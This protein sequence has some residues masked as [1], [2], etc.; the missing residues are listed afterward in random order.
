MES[1]IFLLLISCLSTILVGGFHRE[2]FFVRHNQFQQRHKVIRTISNKQLHSSFKDSADNA[3]LKPSINNIIIGIPKETIPSERRVA[4]TPQTVAELI[5]QNFTV[6][7]E[8]NAG[9]GST[10]SNE[11]Y[12]AVGASIVPRSMVWKAD[13]LVSY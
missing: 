10:I 9:I 2:G 11:E 1:K 8:E 7:V 6:W 3:A 5:Q 13:I 4:Q 12:K